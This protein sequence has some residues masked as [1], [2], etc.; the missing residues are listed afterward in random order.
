MNKTVFSVNMDNVI[1]LT[2]KLE[3]INRSA[4]PIAVRQTLND[5][6]FT[7]KRMVPKVAA[8]KFTT[9]QKNFFSAFSTVVM[10]KGYDV[11]RMVSVTGINSAKG[12]EV[13]EGLEKQE[14]GGTITGSKLIPH[15]MARVSSNQ[16]KKV[17]KSNYLSNISISTAKNK[18]KDAKFLLVKKG[19]GGTVFEIRKTKTRTRLRP[20]YVYR[21]TNKSKVDR[22]PFMEPSAKFARSKMA[23]DYKKN[24]EYQF[25]RALS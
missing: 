19:R 5:A 22:T 15:R 3:R 8:Q 9:R 11:N 1:K 23:I 20:V 12:S 16:Q 4:F 25:K 21:R 2:A 10:A 17:R 24:A 13:A 6:A 18:K 14:T 7:T